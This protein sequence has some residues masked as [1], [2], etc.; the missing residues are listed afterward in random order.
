MCAC[1]KS[2]DTLITSSLSAELWAG[3]ITVMCSFVCCF[4]RDPGIGIKC[5]LIMHVCGC[6]SV[7]A[8]S[9]IS[10]YQSKRTDDTDYSQET[11]TAFVTAA[12]AWHVLRSPFSELCI[13]LERNKTKSIKDETF[14]MAVLNKL[15]ISELHMYSMLLLFAFERLYCCAREMERWKT[16]TRRVSAS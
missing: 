3:A 5:A 15:I 13:S 11:S 4:T 9:S 1:A 6:V 16:V 12:T 10:V 14:L 7:C 2:A 8:P